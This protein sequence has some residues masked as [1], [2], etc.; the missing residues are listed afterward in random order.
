MCGLIKVFS[1]LSHDFLC[2]ASGTACANCS[3]VVVRWG[4]VGGCGGVGGVGGR[5]WGEW[6]EGA[7][8][9][10]VEVVGVGPGTV[11]PHTTHQIGNCQLVL[12]F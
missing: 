11:S 5:G 7:A 2:L 3:V 6:V 1:S 10:G 9:G 4:G 8:R 12:P